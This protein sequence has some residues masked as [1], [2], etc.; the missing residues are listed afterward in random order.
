MG[1]PYKG[2]S[3]SCAA[4]CCVAG[5]PSGEDFWGRGPSIQTVVAALQQFADVTDVASPAEWARP[6]AD[7]GFLGDQSPRSSATPAA[8]HGGKVHLP[9]KPATEWPSLDAVLTALA[10]QPEQRSA[11]DVDMLLPLLQRMH[12]AR[13]LPEAAQR[14]LCNICCATNVQHGG[15]VYRKGDESDAVH[16]VLHGSINLI[17][18]GDPAYHASDI[19][20]AIVTAGTAFGDSTITDSTRLRN[21]DAVA[22]NSSCTLMTLMRQDYDLVINAVQAEAFFRALQT[23]GTSRSDAQIALVK[24]IVCDSVEFFGGFAEDT[25]RE[26]ARSFS[27]FQTNQDQ[28][29]YTKETPAD[30]MFICLSGTV[31]IH[32]RSLQRGKRAA[33]KLHS[34]PSPRKEEPNTE[35]PV[36]HAFQD[37]GEGK[38]QQRMLRSQGAALTVHRG[39]T[40]QEQYLSSLL[41]ERK[42]R[43]SPDRRAKGDSARLQ[44]S[45][46]SAK[47]I[48][49][50]QD[51]DSVSRC[52]DALMLNAGLGS[53]EA[54]LEKLEPIS[55]S[56]D[57]AKFSGLLLTRS[58]STS[59]SS[60]DQLAP[61][62]DPAAAAVFGG[63]FGRTASTGSTGS[64]LLER[65]G[66]CLSVGS[67]GSVPFV[68]SA[69]DIF[70]ADDLASEQMRS[71][72]HHAR[73]KLPGLV[74]VLSRSDYRRIVMGINDAEI[75]GDLLHCLCRAF[76]LHSNQHYTL[77]GDGSEMETSTNLSSA[78]IEDPAEQKRLTQAQEDLLNALTGCFAFETIRSGQILGRQNQNMSD[79]FL[80]AT[81][82]CNVSIELVSTRG[83]QSTNNVHPRP[84]RPK[85]RR[86]LRDKISVTTLGKYA[87]VGFADV[88]YNHD[89]TIGRF[90][91]SYEAT[92]DMHLFRAPVWKVMAVLE[93]TDDNRKVLAML[94]SKA[95]RVLLSWASRLTQNLEVLQETREKGGEPNFGLC[96][97]A[98]RHL[99]R[100][101]HPVS[102]V[103]LGLRGLLSHEA[104]PRTASS[105]PQTG[106]EER[107]DVLNSSPLPSPK[108]DS[109]V[110]RAVQQRPPEDPELLS[111]FKAQLLQDDVRYSVV[112]RIARAREQQRLTLKAD[113]CRSQRPISPSKVPQLKINDVL[114]RRDRIEA[115]ATSRFKHVIPVKSKN[116]PVDCRWGD[117]KMTAGAWLTERAARNTHWLKPHLGLKFSESATTR[118]NPMLGKFSSDAAVKV[119]NSK[120]RES[121][122]SK[123]AV[124]ISQQ[125]LANFRAIDESSCCSMLC[126]DEVREIVLERAAID[127]LPKLGSLRGMK[128][129]PRTRMRPVT[130]AFMIPAGKTLCAGM[131][132]PFDGERTSGYLSTVAVKAKKIF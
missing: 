87:L 131:K 91:A 86:K 26:F 127:V 92:T 95:K 71:Y 107:D 34:H 43:R 110:P 68:L 5:M 120:A 73:A 3:V 12:A 117:V 44:T 63:R 51:N 130:R 30:S 6:V 85:D 108:E 27:I 7:G 1:G 88:L 98:E 14:A 24:R 121:V 38:I 84:S 18:P 83:L 67:A 77:Q 52:R 40:T 41:D 106:R 13:S 17:L 54:I 89:K 132:M 113:T 25:R 29:L 37:Q 66:S 10:L 65:T 31:E 124:T 72:R 59:S 119:A 69:G 35:N 19:E 64:D 79:F 62:L 100:L 36:D 32:A 50:V 125:A 53:Q 112:A 90:L 80:V 114:L 97:E 4:S 33:Y 23:P 58:T 102:S 46:A 99:R 15:Y 116:P 94:S 109:T 45:A 70:G 55:G 60:L 75:Q 82:V 118:P 93:R 28:L 122:E 39:G 49:R 96:S 128:F 115:L 81:G 129:L 9:G 48:S 2:D 47:S 111:T 11:A 57:S 56:T 21:C 76:Q 103:E 74:L 20:M 104:P 78:G 101:R 61:S 42:S 105:R 126:A 22:L 16:V 123:P 8:G